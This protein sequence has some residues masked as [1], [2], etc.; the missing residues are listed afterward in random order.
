MKRRQNLLT[1]FQNDRIQRRRRRCRRGHRGG[2]TRRRR[3]HRFDDGHV[4]MDV[5][6]QRHVLGG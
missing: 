6:L 3:R 1:R 5:A 4:G 2:V